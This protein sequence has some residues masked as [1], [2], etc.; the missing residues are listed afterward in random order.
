VQT[1]EYTGATG[2]SVLLV[3]VRYMY[4]SNVEEET[5]MCKPLH[6]HNTTEDILNLID[7]YMAEGCERS[8]FFCTC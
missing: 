5:L 3:F 1:D 2:L 6:T 7:L 8:W 4:D